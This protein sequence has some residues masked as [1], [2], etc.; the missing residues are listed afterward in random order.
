MSDHMEPKWSLVDY[1]RTDVTDIV[2]RGLIQWF[3]F[4]SR[5]IIVLV[6]VTLDFMCAHIWLITKFTALSYMQYYIK[7]RFVY[8][9]MLMET[10]L[11]LFNKHYFGRYNIIRVPE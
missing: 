4:L 7:K 8:F 10:C 2:S 11:L 6:L 1:V 3:R 5:G 9:C